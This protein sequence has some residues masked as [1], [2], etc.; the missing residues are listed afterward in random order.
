M[1][2]SIMAILKNAFFFFFLVESDQNASL[3]KSMWRAVEGM[4]CYPGDLGDSV[5]SHLQVQAGVWKQEGGGI[6]GGAKAS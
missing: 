1:C 2:S 6:G 5:G 4:S 3:Y